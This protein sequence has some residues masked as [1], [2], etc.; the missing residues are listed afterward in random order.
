MHA[1]RFSLPFLSFLFA[2]AF[3]PLMGPSD[4]L[5]RIFFSFF[6]RPLSGVFAGMGVLVLKANGILSC[7]PTH[8]LPHTLPLAP[9]YPSFSSSRPR[10]FGYP[11]RRPLQ[12]LPVSLPSMSDIPLFFQRI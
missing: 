8:T 9:S 6:C 11:L 7:F 10:I 4:P 2:A 12:L 1:Q 3:C 5:A